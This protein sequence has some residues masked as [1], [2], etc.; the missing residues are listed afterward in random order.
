MHPIAMLSAKLASALSGLLAPEQLT[1][2]QERLVARYAN[3][4]R[5]AFS[6]LNEDAA[7]GH[8]VV[9]WDLESAIERE[10]CCVL[11]GRCS[12]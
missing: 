7:A 5:L 10:S 9:G 2:L 3:R 8:S 4:F 11:S 1:S 12:S 6:L